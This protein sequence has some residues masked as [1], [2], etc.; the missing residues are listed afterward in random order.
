MCIGVL[1]LLHHHAPD[2]T[3]PFMLP[4]VQPQGSAQ[5]QATLQ[6]GGISRE[7]RRSAPG[8]FRSSIC[9]LG[10]VNRFRSGRCSGRQ[11]LPQRVYGFLGPPAPD[12]RPPDLIIGA[13]CGSRPQYE[14]DG[15]VAA[16]PLTHLSGPSQD[17]VPNTRSSGRYQQF[18][19][20]LDV[21]PPDALVYEAGLGVVFPERLLLLLLAPVVLV[22]CLAD[23]YLN[24]PPV[25]VIGEHQRPLAVELK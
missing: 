16:A 2:L 19:L 21:G 7:D 15:F 8:A 22:A 12:Q 17:E 5:T 14:V 25:A 20:L 13:A 1:L 23:N 9:L 10:T 6:A 4:G 3:R 11:M 24:E 18:A